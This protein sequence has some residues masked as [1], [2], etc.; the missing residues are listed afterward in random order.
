MTSMRPLI[1]T[2]AGWLLAGAVMGTAIADLP[3]GAPEYL[4]PDPQAPIV[5]HEGGWV[6][7]TPDVTGGGTTRGMARGMSRGMARGMSR[8]MARGMSRGMARGMSRGMARG[9]SRGDEVTAQGDLQAGPALPDILAP[10]APERVGWTHDA[11]PRLYWYISAPWSGEV[12]FTLT[13]PDQ[14]EPLIETW[15]APPSGGAHTAG[16]H[17]I[18]L[19][20]LGVTLKPG[21]EYEWFVYIM[22]DPVE[23]SADLVG[24]ATIRYVPDLAPGVTEYHALAHAGLWYD[25]IEALSREIERKPADA[26]LKAAR[27]RLIEQVGMPR[28]AAYDRGGRW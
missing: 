21:E 22:P 14:D 7:D 27:A 3:H 19:A 28:V 20:R 18:D 13:R 23:R 25:A 26:N 10:L 6:T 4:A 1:K 2:G 9:M 11:Q 15:I 24:S 16:V 17:A 8:G 5:R 12:G